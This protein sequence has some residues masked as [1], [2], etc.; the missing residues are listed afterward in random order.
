MNVLSLFDGV[1][2]GR[3]ALE[4]A[5]IHVD[6]YYA[7]EIDKYAIQIAKKNYPDTVEL[8]D[9]NNWKNWNLPKIDLLIGGSPCTNLSFAGNGKGLEG[10]ESK[11]FY[12]FVEILKYYKPKYFLLE[13][14]KMKKEWENIITKELGVPAVLINSKIFSAQSR[15]RLYWTNIPLM[16]LPEDKEILLKDILDNDTEPVILHNLYGGFK[17]KKVRIFTEKSPTIRTAKGGG[18]IPS[19][20]KKGFSKEFFEGKAYKD[21]KHLG[22]IRKL[23]PVECE[24]LQNLPTDYTKGISD[25]RRYMAIGNGW[26]VDV[27]AYIFSS[28]KE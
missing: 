11:L 12:K 27:V 21:F 26:T 17:E 2:C 15:E 20:A 23:T 28:V 10:I 19:V 25:S 3:V 7:S 14:V 24:K 9:V 5:G 8:G 4:R 13:N 1:S 6:N 22:C 16:N 18:H